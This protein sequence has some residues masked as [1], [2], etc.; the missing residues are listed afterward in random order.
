MNKQEVFERLNKIKIDLSNAAGASSSS[1]AE[2]VRAV[3]APVHDLV[4]LIEDLVVPDPVIAVEEGYEDVVR[5]QLQTKSL[6]KFR[7]PLQVSATAPREEL[8]E[9]NTEPTVSE[10]LPSPAAST[11]ETAPGSGAAMMLADVPLK[12]DEGIPDNLIVASPATVAGLEAHAFE[13]SVV[14]PAE[15]DVATQL[16]NAGPAPLEP[17]PAEEGEAK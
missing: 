14:I 12:I 16:E 1:A 17:V 4:K 10:P 6:E 5:R 11:G 15:P 3:V 8:T 13:K 7:Q 2:H 9:P